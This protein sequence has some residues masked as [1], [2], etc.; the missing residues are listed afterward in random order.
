MVET[1][2]SIDDILEALGRT[3]RLVAENAEELKAQEERRNAS[4]DRLEAQIADTGKFVKELG[5]QLGGMANSNCAFAEDYFY[6]ALGATMQFR[7]QHYDTM[8]GGLRQ[9]K[10]GVQDEFDVVLYN[11]KSVA[12]IEVKYKAD[13]DDLDD[14]ATRKLEHFRLFFPPTKTTAST[15]A[16]PACRSKRGL[17]AKPAH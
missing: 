5:K 4:L 11:G 15:S 17:S 16:L 12:I 2:R 6:N 13:L 8:A 10:D 1:I 14:L 3:E 7:D 9:R